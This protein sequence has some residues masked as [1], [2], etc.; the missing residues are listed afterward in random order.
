[1][2]AERIPPPRRHYEER[3]SSR[4]RTP[5]DA[6]LRVWLPAIVGGGVGFVWVVWIK[7]PIWIVP[8]MALVTVLIVK[9][10]TGA[11]SWMIGE[12]ALGATG[13]ST[14]YKRG[15]SEAEALTMQGK[16]A[17]AVSA[18]EA[19]IADAPEDPEPYLRIAR[20]YKKELDNLDD[21]AFWFRRARR[22]AQRSAGQD[23]AA[24]RQLI[25][26]YLA[27][28]DRR[29]AI[30]ELARI[31]ERFADTPEGDWAVGLLTDLKHPT[32]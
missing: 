2:N 12:G 3:E 4:E 16:Y 8:V 9:M 19:A 5:M 24:S 29:R 21:A 13:G 31:A 17:Y 15:Y 6:H 28:D 30:P 27:S 26:L 22:A 25:E 14:P 20:L 11:A 7:F 18:S 10:F 23:L 1:M 32:S